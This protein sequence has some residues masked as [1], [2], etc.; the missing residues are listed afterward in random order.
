[1]ARLS[2]RTEE[3]LKKGFAYTFGYSRNFRPILY[4][5]PDLINF[6]DDHFFNSIYVLFYI[7][8]RYRMVPYHCEKLFLVIDL[9][10]M[11]VS[12]I[13]LTKIYDMLKKIHVCYT[14]NA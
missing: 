1:M 14:E 9:N 4:V 3:D 6:S 10:H 13:P 11:R 2:Y 5:R 8:Q 7:C 12:Q